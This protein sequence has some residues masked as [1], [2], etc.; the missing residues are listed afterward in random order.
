[1]APSAI[2]GTRHVRLAPIDGSD[3]TIPG[4]ELTAAHA[5]LTLPLLA[6]RIDLRDL[7]KILG[8]E[9]QIVQVHLEA[10]RKVILL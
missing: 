9:P 4:T 10:I 3:F 1:V 2:Y 6:S 5:F 7:R 8:V